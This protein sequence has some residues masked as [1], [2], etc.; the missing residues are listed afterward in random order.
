[1][2]AEKNAS[3]KRITGQGGGLEAEESF[4]PLRNIASDEARQPEEKFQ[5]RR[6]DRT[7]AG[8]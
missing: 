4:T 5:T 7:T 2:T 6:T 8:L 1:M 3:W